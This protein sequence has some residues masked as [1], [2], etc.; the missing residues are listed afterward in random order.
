M[1]RE[2][3]PKCPF[4]RNSKLSPRFINPQKNIVSTGFDVTI[5]DL[6]KAASAAMTLL[7]VAAERVCSPWLRYSS[8]AAQSLRVSVYLATTYSNLVGGDCALSSGENFVK[9]MRG[10]ALWSWMS[11]LHMDCMQRWMRVLQARAM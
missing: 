7:D 5:G 3:D 4:T 10:I 6:Q 2:L 1:L 9:T 8:P 11:V